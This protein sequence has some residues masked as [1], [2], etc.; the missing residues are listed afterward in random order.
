VEELALVC[1]AE[2]NYRNEVLKGRFYRCPSHFPLEEIIIIRPL[3]DGDTTESIPADIKPVNIVN[4]AFN[5]TGYPRL[6]LKEDE[7]FVLSK[8]KYRRVIAATKSDNNGLVIVAPIYTLKKYHNENF[9]R[10]DLINNRI[11]G[12][13]YLEE[14]ENNK[15][16]FIS[17]MESFPINKDLLTPIK[18]E[19]NEEGLNIFDEHI[20]MIYDLMNEN[21]SH[22]E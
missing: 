11:P 20:F 1:E 18:L 21:Y 10:E 8:L 3:H 17:L 4:N 13:I 19:L 5:H 14:A 12:L 16:S 9:N 7:E 15:E 22:S 6:G 2:G